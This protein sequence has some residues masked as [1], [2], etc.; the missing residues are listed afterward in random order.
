MNEIYRTL[1]FLPP[2]ASTIAED[3][4]RLHYFVITVT[5]LGSTAVLA[6]ALYFT[7]RYRHVRRFGPRQRH[8]QMPFR[9]EVGLV[10]GLLALF[11][12]WWWI[13]IR[14]FLDMREA[15]EDGVEVYVMGKQ[16]MWKFTYPDGS[17]SISRL[18]VPAGTPVKLLM[19]SRDVIH[20]FYVPQ[21]RVKHDVV[22]G[23]YTT[24]WFEA[25][26]PGVYEILCTEYC[27]EGHS[28]MRG[29]VH[30]LPPD[31]FGAWRDG[32]HRQAIAPQ[33]YVE[34]YV[35]EAR[36]APEQLDLA[37][38]G[39]RVAAQQG[40]LRCHTTDGSPHI[41]PSFA[42]LHGSMVDLADGTRIVA[43]T[44]Y[45]TRSIMDPLADLRQGYQPVMPSYQGV[46]THVETAAIV[47]FIRSLRDFEPDEIQ[48]PD[49]PLLPG[50][51]SPSPA[52]RG[53]PRYPAN[54]PPENP[55]SAHQEERP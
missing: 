52:A 48:M 10:L 20:S 14:Q 24:L 51:P 9:L 22:P 29:T 33:D 32:R 27:G 19:T 36:T 49:L 44:A 25:K 4:D 42:G 55:S 40:C 5:M 38:L 2:Q 37:V 30:V 34:P 28:T 11:L 53:T 21:F 17:S 3:L 43:D 41:G 31:E 35:I 18:Y 23:R 7:V 8:W 15:P 16:W 39:E 54:Q 6:I 13:G 26:Q 47:E 46:L 50:R 1:L 45:I 12:W